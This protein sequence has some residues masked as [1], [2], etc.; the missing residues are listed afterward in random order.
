MNNR[1]IKSNDAGGGG[2]TNTVDNYNPFPDGG[3]VALYQ[4]NG[5]AT[6]VSG[7][8]DGTA[9]NV[10]YGTGVFGQAA[11]FNGSS[12]IINLP[13]NSFKLTTL[14]ISCWIKVDSFTGEDYIY[15]GYDETPSVGYGVAVSTDTGNKIKFRSWLYP[16]FKEVI[17]NT[18]LSTGVWY[19][20]AFAAT[21]SK[22]DI[23]IN[24]VLDKTDSLIGFNYAPT[25]TFNIGALKRSSDP[26]PL[27]PFHGSIDQ[28]RIFNRALRPYEVEA[29]YTE[30]YCTPTIV[31]SEHFNTV[32]YTGDE[33]TSNPI[34]GVGF[35]PD[36]VW[37]KARSYSQGHRIYDAVRGVAKHLNSE[38]TAAEA[39]NAEGLKSFDSDGF[40]LGNY[41]PVNDNNENFVAWNFKAG[42]A[43]VTNTDG[44]ITSQVSAN[45]EAGFSIVSYTGN[46][47]GGASVGHGLGVQPSITIQKNLSNSASWAVIGKTL[48]EANGGNKSYLLFDT[49]NAMG[50]ASQIAADSNVIYNHSDATNNAN[51][52]NYIAYCFAEVEGFSSIGSYVGTGTTVNVVTGFEPAMIIIKRTDSIE[53][54]KIIDN[55]RGDFANSLEPNESIAEEAGNNSNF[56]L[57]AN[58]FTIGDTSGD[59]NANGGKYIYMAFAADPT[60]VEPT[61]EDS[62]NTVTYTGNGGTQTI[63]GVFEGG[64]SFNGSNSKIT[65]VSSQLPIP[66]S[67]AFTVSFWA[68][69]DS[70]LTQ[71]NTCMMSFGDF[72]L[73]SEYVTGR[74][75]LGDVNVGYETTSSM[76][77]GWNHCVLT[78]DASNNINLY[79]NGA[80]E[81]TGNKS[82]SRTNG[83][84]FA[85]G[86]ARLSNP[87]YYFNGELDQV[88]IFNT[89]LT[90]EQ[91]TELYEETEA[92]SHTLNFP[93][94]AG[95]VALYELNGNANDTGG[96]YNGT[97]SNVTW[98]HNGVG[99]QPDLVWVKSRV[100]ANSHKLYD[101]TRGTFKALY[102]NATAAE[103]NDSPNG[104]ISFDN[105]GFSVKDDSNGN[106]GVNGG[107]GGT[108]SGNPPN[109]VA[110]CWKGAELPAINSNGSIPSVVSAN[111]AAGFSI[112]SYTGNDV[113]GNIS[114]GHGLSQAPEIVIRKDRNSTEH[115]Q[116]ITTVIDGSND[117]LWLDD[118]RAAGNASQ[119]P[120]TSSVFYARKDVYVNENNSS[121]SYINYCFHSVAGFSK[122]GSYTGNG[123]TNGPTIT[124]GFEPA[125]VMLKRTDSTAPWF[126]FDN[127]R[128]PTNNRN[129]FLKADD[130]AAEA[131]GGV[132]D[133]VSFNADN[134]K[135]TSDPPS[136][137]GSGGTYIYMAFA[138]QF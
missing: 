90:A 25:N 15:D 88:R 51:G 65:T 101:S 18:A 2:C 78:V 35:Q 98:L 47:V 55:K 137:N 76:G 106:Y 92:D 132:N 109:Y 111:P 8:Y 118:T 120:S 29:L 5:D 46:G 61:L 108:Y 26:S 70:S 11:V 94:G 23:Y 72:W 80:N 125:F 49:S 38:N 126:M 17:S 79:L 84:N 66:A 130:S 6:D 85:I 45:T 136:M 73:K 103:A 50:V 40:T 121:N 56:L 19:H 59:Y 91:V 69:V 44:T 10:T 115:W 48:E 4:L 30:E 71:Y 102:S 22:V 41:V 24:G 107:I 134:F 93:S 31:P 21:Q 36:F 74:F 75:G 60:T 105:N 64:G 117:F 100:A 1:L 87:V 34:T 27:V 58:G 95:A 43:A 28:V 96:T 20:I 16:N 13:N 33:T 110:W 32:T 52:N 14:T 124:T 127:K 9:T 128:N 37:I 114:V 81:F 39:T 12:S 53:D 119:L 138:N 82:I 63:G 131:T 122:F 113:S 99:F 135:L 54:W 129:K 89:E 3:G 133:Y 57:S 42:G 112:V 77:Y 116:F 86:V 68:K 67:G 62:F 97:A 7:N 83:G 123:S 104:V